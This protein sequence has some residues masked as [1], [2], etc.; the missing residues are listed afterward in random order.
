MK[1][2]PIREKIKKTKS[3]LNYIEKIQSQASNLKKI[4]EH[5]QIKTKIEFEKEHLNAWNTCI[6]LDGKEKSITYHFYT[7]LKTFYEL[8]F[9]YQFINIFLAKFPSIKLLSTHEL[10]ISFLKSY[11][12]I[13]G[14]FMMS[15]HDNAKPK[16]TLTEDCKFITF[17]CLKTDPWGLCIADDFFLSSHAYS[18]FRQQVEQRWLQWSERTPVAFW[19]GASTGSVLTKANWQDNRRVRLC[20]IAKQHDDEQFIDAKI[21]KLIQIKERGVKK[22]IRN[23]GLVDSYIP[24]IEFLKYKYVI[25]IDGN[26]NSWPGLFTK[27]LTGSCAL[28]VESPWKQ[29]YYNNLKPWVNYIPIKNDMSDLIEKVSWCHEHDDKARIIGENGR[30]LALSMTMETETS[31]AYKTILESLR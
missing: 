20:Q 21:T 31:K 19:R 14:S 11:P 10:F 22:M 25:D 18:Q 29:W 4:E 1:L 6:S 13:K 2:Q 9:P 12:D 28:K 15:W 26:S 17:T 7:N 5:S 27:L 8:N 16:N 23:A 24:T 3:G 30:K